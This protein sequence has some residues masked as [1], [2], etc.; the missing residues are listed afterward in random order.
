MKLNV[1]KWIDLQFIGF[2]PSYYFLQALLWTSTDPAG[3]FDWKNGVRCYPQ[4]F[5]TTLQIPKVN[6]MVKPCGLSAQDTVLYFRMPW[7]KCLKLNR[8]LPTPPSGTCQE[9][10]SRTTKAQCPSQSELSPS[11][12]KDTV[13]DIIKN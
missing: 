9:N 5:V 2:H 4:I 12:Q 6:R 3:S 11:L 7:H 8:N 1:I 13:V 10:N